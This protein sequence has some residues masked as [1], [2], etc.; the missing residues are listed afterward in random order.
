MG[1]DLVAPTPVV[2]D[3]GGSERGLWREEVGVREWELPLE[4]RKLYIN[5]LSYKS[6]FPP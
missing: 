5:S 6:I 1:E 4:T 3:P 2:T